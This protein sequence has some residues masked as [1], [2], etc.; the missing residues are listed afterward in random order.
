MRQS[1]VLASV[2]LPTSFETG[3]LLTSSAVLAG[4]QALSILSSACLPSTG[5]LSLCRHRVFSESCCS[6]QPVSLPISKNTASSS[7]FFLL[8][9]L[10]R[11]SWNHFHQGHPRFC[12]LNLANPPFSSFCVCWEWSQSLCMQDRGLPC[13][14]PQSV[15]TASWVTF[16]LL[17]TVL[18]RG[19]GTAWEPWQVGRAM[20][21]SE[22]D[23]GALAQR[24][25]RGVTCKGRSTS[26]ENPRW[27]I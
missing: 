8:P 16:R 6:N 7:I 3:S 25:L 2:V 1:W 13:S 18:L 19:M 5:V 26:S 27:G 12:W 9:I 17:G 21:V 23:C 4:Q 11:H 22:E 15:N 14:C 10:I 20:P 24:K